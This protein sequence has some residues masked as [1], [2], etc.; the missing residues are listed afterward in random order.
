MG[1]DYRT[2]FKE[3]NEL[4]IDYLVVGGLAMNFH[5]VPRMTYDVD[6]MILLQ[7]ENI[8]KLTSQ[9]RAWGYKPKVPIELEDFAT[10]AKRP[11]WIREKGMK[12][13]NFYAEG[14]PIGEIDIVIDCPISYVELKNRS[15][16]VELGEVKVPVVSIHDLIQLKKEAGRKQDIADIES[17]EL[18]LEK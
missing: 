2:I 8:R 4:G 15:V 10:E 13:L 7:P 5:G 9:L 17:L 14:L 12:A 1:L 3:L 16:K 6:L 18:V 11:S